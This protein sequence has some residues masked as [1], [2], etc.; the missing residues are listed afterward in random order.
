MAV[1]NTQQKKLM[2]ATEAC[3]AARAQGLKV[4]PDTVRRLARQL[5]LA[6][7]FGDRIFIDR[8]GWLQLLETG[9]PDPMAV[10]ERSR[11]GAQTGA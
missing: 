2:T 3:H 8:A 11:S 10:R 9:H 7:K 5:G 1:Q 6:F 4:N